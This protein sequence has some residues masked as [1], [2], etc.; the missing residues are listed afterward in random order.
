MVIDLENPRQYPI[1]QWIRGI[2]SWARMGPRIELHH[3]LRSILTA[4]VQFKKIPKWRAPWHLKQ[5]SPSSCKYRRGNKIKK[6]P[7]CS[8]PHVWIATER[9]TKKN[10]HRPRPHL[11][12]GSDSLTCCRKVTGDLCHAR[13]PPFHIQRLKEESN[14]STTIAKPS[15]GD[16]GPIWLHA[17]GCPP[18]CAE[19]FWRNFFW[20]K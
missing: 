19:F 2:W 10:L 11:R 12:G 7:E 13:C 5:S 18:P 14:F 15:T 9:R 16:S 17:V 8:R 4:S 6:L 3:S 1:T 20:R